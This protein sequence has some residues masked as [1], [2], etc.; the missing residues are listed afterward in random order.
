MDKLQSLYNDSIKNNSNLSLKLKEAEAT[1]TAIQ[2]GE[3]DAIITQEGSDGPKVYTLEG[4]DHLYRRLVQGMNE[5]VV[6]LTNKGT[7]FYSN[8]ELAS[9]L[10]IPLEKI[11]GKQ[12]SSFIHPRDMKIF[13]DFIKDRSATKNEISMISLDG[14]IIPVHISVNT[15]EEFKGLYLI[16]TDLRKQKHFEALQFANIELNN[17]LKELQKSEERFHSVLDNSQ[18]VIYRFNIQKGRYEYISPSA[19]NLTGYSIKEFMEL[20][21]DNPFLMVHPDDTTILKEGIVEL[22]NSGK[23]ELEYRQQIKN[24]SYIWIS[25]HMSLIKD[26]NGQPKYR[27]G[28]IHDITG[29]KEIELKL[30]DNVTN[31][32]RSNQELEQFAYVASHDLREP[33]RMIT[34]FLQLLE[35]RYKDKLDSD[36]NEFIDYAVNGAKRLDSMIKDL[37]QYS[38]VTRKEVIFKP[39][40]TKSVV[41]ETLINLKVPID[42]NNASITYDSL[43]VIYAD[44]E[45]M[46]LL[47]QNLISNSIKY[48]SKEH[49]I[50]HISAS[51]EKDKYLFSVKDNGIGMSPNHLERIFTIFQ[52]LHTMDEFEGTGIGLSIAQKIVHQHGGEIWVESELGKGTTFYFTI[53]IKDDLSIF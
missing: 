10:K 22:E 25:N 46:V 26:K 29:R 15:L 23:V 34:S 12:L 13:K 41:E 17:S 20:E 35:R 45:L 6:T 52:R 24:D 40:N 47:L 14:T 27:D 43:P 16:V 5:G 19:K 8:A 48:R 31:L 51:T 28:N 39:V 49:P 1:L 33:L 53:S 3:I 9:M 37:L 50:I 7:I 21:E 38:K 44:P 2:N 30:N 32:A 42:E 4:A 18:N 36:A 11:T